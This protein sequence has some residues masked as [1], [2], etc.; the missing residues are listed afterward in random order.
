MSKK[1]LYIIGI[2]WELYILLLLKEKP[3]IEEKNQVFI[4]KF[5]S[6]SLN[7]FTPTVLQL[8]LHHFQKE[9]MFLVALICLSVSNIIKKVI[10]ALQWYFIAGS[11]VEQGGTD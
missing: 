6:S 1:L 5:E 10:N 3:L 4:F 9:V 2:L 8:L 7:S 11:G